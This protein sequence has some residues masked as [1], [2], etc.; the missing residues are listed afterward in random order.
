VA[1]ELDPGF[2]REGLF[3]HLL[4][5]FAAAFA[6]AIGALVVALIVYNKTR[7]DQW[8]IFR[9]EAN[10]AAQ[11]RAGEEQERQSAIR[12]ALRYEV[13]DNL[14]RLGEFWPQMTAENPAYG[15]VEE[16]VA[17]RLVDATVPVWTTGIWQG[18]AATVAVALSSDQL[19]ATYGLYATLAE[20]SET[21][22]RLQ[23]ARESDVAALAAQ[24]ET[25]MPS[26]FGPRGFKFQGTF[27]FRDAAKALIP[28]LTSKVET[29][30]SRGNPIPAEITSRV[31][32]QREGVTASTAKQNRSL[33]SRLLGR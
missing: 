25:P 20:V 6:G 10:I 14:R 32:D 27:Y 33:W 26:A 16:G 21:Q 3:A 31:D 12:A 9:E 5:E 18:A 28:D 15:T 30:L 4:V 24:P 2:T 8:A 19:A 13:V 22:H 11:V 7:N 17:A 1:I 23:A 29:A